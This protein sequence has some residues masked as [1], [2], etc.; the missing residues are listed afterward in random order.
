[1]GLVAAG[2]VGAAAVGGGLAAYG[3]SRAQS[4]QNKAAA[5]SAATQSAQSFYDYL[6]SRGVNIQ[7]IVAND[8][9]GPNFWTDQYKIARQQGTKADFNT[10]LYQALKAAPS[11]PVWDTI[12]NPTAGNGAQNTTQPSYVQIGGQAAQPV[13]AGLAG[14]IFQNQTNGTANLPPELQQQTLDAQFAAANPGAIEW[15]NGLKASPQGFNGTLA[16]AV[17]VWYAQNPDAVPD[18]LDTAYLSAT[19]QL[20]AK[21]AQ[22]ATLNQQQAAVNQNVTNLLNGSN[23][24]AQQAALQPALDARAQ[25][26]A[27]QQTL[28]DQQRAAAQNVNT[29]ELTGLQ[30]LANVRTTGAGNVYDANVAA[31]QG[32]NSATLAGL[33]NLLGT[34]QQG[35]QDIYGAA[36][37]GA[38][39]ISAADLAGLQ[40]VLAA[41]ETAANNVYGAQLT[42]ADTYGQAAQQ[43]L[44][45]QLAAQQANRARQGFIG[46]SSGSDLERARLM[47]TALQQGAGARANAGV[48]LQQSLGSARTGN[49]QGQLQD[50]INLA[51][52]ISN[53]GVN[54]ATQLSSANEQN[55]MGQLQAGVNLANSL[56]NAGTTK[57]STI[58]GAN[59]QLASGNLAANTQLATTNAGLLNANADIAKQQA[60]YQNAIDQLNLLVNNQSQQLNA[61]G[62]PNSVASSTIALQNQQNQAA[63]SQLTAYLNSIAPLSINQSNGPQVVTSTP[64]AVMNGYQIGGAALSSG[65]SAAG[66][67]YGGGSLASLLSGLGGSSGASGGGN[68][69]TS[70]SGGTG[71]LSSLG[72]S[73]VFSNVS[74]GGTTG[75]NFVNWTPS[76][77]CWVAREIYSVTDLRWLKFRDW[78]LNRASDA[79]RSFYLRNG[80]DIAKRIENDL[81]AKLYLRNYFDA[82]L[83]SA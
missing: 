17:K 78:V 33:S 47:A 48:S 5:Q 46:T 69:A 39:Q 24:A 42:Q 59:E 54:R 83:A 70:G 38:N 10:W 67:L 53:A 6:S 49:A 11:D 75:S 4:A 13:I 27:L 51:T 63:Y 9:R 30:D 21:T 25:A 43:A 3:T 45:Q 81:G 68:L 74:T 20:Q 72:Q 64:G 36:T 66:S 44:Q 52:A 37:T 57:A 8:P 61:S 19:S 82:V 55:S 71:L 28:I 77:S 15:Y 65:A 76:T 62:L 1:M 29:T 40:K 12:A 23:L 79:F 7:Q 26:A 41:Q 60:A 80:S 56:G 31:A 73:N 32:V 58:A 50:A 35:A 22:A 18:Q 2:I 16:D 34:R 14:Q